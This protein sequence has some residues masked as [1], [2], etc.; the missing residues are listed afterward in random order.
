MRF[1][2]SDEI[3]LDF[4]HFELNELVALREDRQYVGQPLKCYTGFEVL[5]F[6]VVT[7]EKVQ[8]SMD[9]LVPYFLELPLQPLMLAEVASLHLI[10]LLA[11]GDHP[12]L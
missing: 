7:V 5:L 2:I 1:C 11:P 9:P 10:L 6:T 4:A 8:N 3:L 12:P